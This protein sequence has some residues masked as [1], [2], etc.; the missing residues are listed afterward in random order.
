VISAK[1]GDGVYRFGGDGGPAVAASFAGAS[2]LAADRHGNLYVSDRLNARI[3]KVTPDGIINTV[4]GNGQQGFSG[5]GGPAVNA[6]LNYPTGIAIDP[7]GNLYIADADNKRVRKVTPSGLIS[8]VAGNGQYGAGGDGGPALN[9]SLSDLTA[10]AIDGAGN[11]YIADMS[12]QRVRKVTSDGTIST[13]VGIGLKGS[14]GDGGPALSAQLDRPWSIALDGAGNL[15]LADLN[16]RRVRKVTELTSNRTAVEYY[17][18]ALKH[19]FLSAYASEQALVDG[20]AAGPG[21]QRTGDRF[22]VLMAAG[23][24]ASASQVCRF[25]G[26]VIPGPNS[27]FYTASPVECDYLKALQASTPAQQPRWNYEGIAFASYLPVNGVCPPEAPVAIYRAY[28]NRA[29]QVDSNHRITSNLA[30]YQALIAQ[31]WAGEG[32]VMCGVQ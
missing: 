10:I 3:R 2:Y 4:A 20:G 6:M 29:A 7:A 28:N 14:A 12:S 32:V 21:W 8:T 5:D 1:A 23:A 30:G 22:G 27:H 16:N 31:G 25:Y 24:P 11:L 19:Y 26:S 18:T 17:N 9:A 13:V 15:Y